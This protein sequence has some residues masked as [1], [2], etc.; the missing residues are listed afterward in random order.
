VRARAQVELDRA[1]VQEEQGAQGRQEVEEGQEGHLQGQDLQFRQC[2]SNRR[3]AQSAWRR[4]QVKNVGRKDRRSKTSTVK[5]KLKAKKPG[6]V[7]LTFKVTS[8]NAGGK[9][10]KQKIKVKK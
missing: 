7:K 5:V 9:T 3:Q 6:K 10:V 8:S 4:H 1:P 2:R